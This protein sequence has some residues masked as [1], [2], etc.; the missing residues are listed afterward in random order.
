M[1]ITVNGRSIEETIEMQDEDMRDDAGQT[2]DMMQEEWGYD[3]PDPDGEIARER[4]YDAQACKRDW[5]IPPQY[6]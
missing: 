5:G 2:M 3:G 4:Y 1:T 6:R